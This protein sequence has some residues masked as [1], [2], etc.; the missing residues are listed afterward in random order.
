MS[1]VPALHCLPS[2]FFIPNLRA[3]DVSGAIYFPMAKHSPFPPKNCW[4]T[5][6][7][8]VS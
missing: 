2:G 7:A 5:G 6:R 3:L 4:C 8:V 1:K